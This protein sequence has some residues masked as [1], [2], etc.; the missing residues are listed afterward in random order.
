L[1][2]SNEDEEKPTYNIYMKFKEEIVWLFDKPILQILRFNL[3]RKNVAKQ[4]NINFWIEYNYLK[5]KMQN[6]MWDNL[7]IDYNRAKLLLVPYPN[8]DKDYRKR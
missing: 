6:Q 1:I 5:K 4:N 8:A 3:N 2:Q 7:I